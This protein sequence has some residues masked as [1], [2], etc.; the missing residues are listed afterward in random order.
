LGLFNGTYFWLQF[1]PT[2]EAGKEN[3]PH[4]PRPGFIMS[5]LF[6]SQPE[7]HR[8]KI[9]VETQTLPT[10]KIPCKIYIYVLDM[11]IKYYSIKFWT[12]NMPFTIIHQLVCAAFV[13]HPN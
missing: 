13:G 3:H 6:P 11:S 7:H 10:S 5:L 1:C 9:Y 2:L 12:K 8:S 4:V